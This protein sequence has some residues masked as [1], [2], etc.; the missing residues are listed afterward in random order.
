MLRSSGASRRCSSTARNPSRNSPKRARPIAIIN[1][2]PIAESTEYRPPTQ[3]QKPNM[4]SG[5]MPK[6]ATLSA[7]V[8]TA[9]K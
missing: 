4:F 2:S 6:A 8:D 5:S 7:A 1:D 3:S 9:T